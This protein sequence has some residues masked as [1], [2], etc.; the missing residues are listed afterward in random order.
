MPTT[1]IILK[2]RL[3]NRT[4]IEYLDLTWNPIVGCS[5][6][7]C[8]VRAHCWAKMMAKRQKHKCKL[9]YEFLPH[10]HSE[11]WIEPFKRKKS[12]R[13]GVCFSGDLF[14]DHWIDTSEQHQILVAIEKC[15]WHTFICLTKQPQNIPFRYF[16]ENMWIGVT[17]NTKKDLWRIDELLRHHCEVHI[18]T[19]EPLYEKL[20]GINLQHIEWLIIG[21]QTRPT[22]LP[23]L[24]WVASLSAQAD[25]QEIPVFLKNNLLNIPKDQSYQEFPKR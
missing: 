15:F 16:P 11:R 10:Y 13:I 23:K 8:A 4:K 5:G 18:V 17:V 2:V 9:C 1:C 19:A 7:G 14:D 21:A 22:L 3:L 6:K 25:K 20:D 12:A 24:E